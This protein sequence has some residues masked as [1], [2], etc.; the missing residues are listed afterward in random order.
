[1]RK[2]FLLAALPAGKV[3]VERIGLAHL[4][5]SMGTSDAGK[6]CLKSAVKKRRFQFR[7][8]QIAA[9]TGGWNRQRPPRL[10]WENPGGDHVTLARYDGVQ[11][12]KG[13][14]GLRDR[15][16]RLWPS[17]VRRDL[18][19]LGVR[20]L[21]RIDEN[22]QGNDFRAGGCQR[23]VSQNRQTTRRP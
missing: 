14:R 3:D 21:N 2:L 5:R 1:M 11:A 10:S 16:D 19:R 15:V 12:G 7:S 20:D 8:D 17:C 22:K 23:V 13:W 18:G 6:N 4:R 9:G